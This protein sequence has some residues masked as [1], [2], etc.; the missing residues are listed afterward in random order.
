MTNSSRRSGPA[1]EDSWV[2]EGKVDSTGS[3]TDEEDTTI[4]QPYRTAAT[5]SRKKSRTTTAFRKSPRSVSTIDSA[6][7]ELVM[8]SLHQ[9]YSPK[10][11][12][13]A[14]A[15]EKRHLPLSS[16]AHSP[17]FQQQDRLKTV[18]SGIWHRK[19]VLQPAL[20]GLSHLASK[21]PIVST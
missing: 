7:P 17:N 19:A 11:R 12:R 9:D 13:R 4:T 8:P 2:L 10:P 18:E 14:Q 6:E 16:N 15:I 5:S 20:Q 1:P 21:F 3:S